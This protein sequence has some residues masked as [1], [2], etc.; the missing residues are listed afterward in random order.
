M[1]PVKKL[2]AYFDRAGFVCPP[3]V[4]P[5][6]FY[7]GIFA[8]RMFCTIFIGGFCADVVSGDVEP[9]SEKMQRLAL[10]KARVAVQ[11]RAESG[12]RR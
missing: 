3:R 12:G 1:G 7:M 4:N 11:H 2:G 5:A 8:D 6:D 10:A 9:H